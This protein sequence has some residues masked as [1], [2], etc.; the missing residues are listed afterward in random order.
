VKLFVV[1]VALVTAITPA[2]AINLSITTADIER[3]LTIARDQDRARER[4]HAAYIVNITDPFVERLEII[5][6]FRRVVLLAEDR[7]RK[8]DRAFAY[9]SRLA[10]IALDPW[11]DRVAVAVRLRFHPHNAYVDVPDITMTLDG[12][13]AERAFVGILKEPVLAMS[14]PRNPAGGVP[15]LGAVAEAVFEATLIGQTRRHVNVAMDGKVLITRQLD[16]AAV[17]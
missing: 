8:G 14:D 1:A 11:H 7:I 3:A 10:A 15:V 6:E 9:S 13:N 17:E 16:F 2:R 4:F 5:S 12:P